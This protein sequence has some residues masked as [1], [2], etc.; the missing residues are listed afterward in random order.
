LKWYF[1][2]IVAEL[3]LCP[4]EILL[5]YQCRFQIGF[6]YRDG[7]QFTGLCDVQS[8]GD[9]KLNFHFNASRTAINIAKMDWLTIPKEE[10]KAFSMS[11][12]NTLNHNRLLLCRFFDVF[13]IDPNKHKNKEYIKELIYYGIIAA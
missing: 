6:L 10:R 13:G 5:F 11:D 2:E 1:E 9:N 3:N 4:K 8:R 12:I 7:K